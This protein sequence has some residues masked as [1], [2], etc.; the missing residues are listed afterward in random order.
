MTEGSVEADIYMLVTHID[1]EATSQSMFLQE[2]GHFVNIAL[3]DNREVVPEG[4]VLI[5][6]PMV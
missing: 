3:T 1:R 4:F 5:T 6:F 2:S